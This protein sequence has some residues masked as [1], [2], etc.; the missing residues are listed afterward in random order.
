MLIQMIGIFL[1]LI[2]LWAYQ[3]TYKVSTQ[4]TPYKLVYGLMS[5]LPIEFVVATN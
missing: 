5:L 1:L 2:A 4:H 3:T